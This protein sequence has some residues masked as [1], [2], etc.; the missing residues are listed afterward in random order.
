MVKELLE[1]RTK[2]NIQELLPQ[3]KNIE[4]GILDVIHRICVE[5][6]LKYSLAYGSLLG[7]VRHQG[8]IPWDDDIDIYMP[9]DDYK[10]FIEILSNN[11]VEGYVL[12]KLEKDNDYINN[13]AKLKKDNTTFLQP[14]EEEYKYHK[15]IFVDIFPCDLRADSSW[16]Q[17]M[18]KVDMMFKNLY[19]RQYVPQESNILVRLV[20]KLLLVIVPRRLHHKLSFGFEK[21]L[22]RKG[23]TG[24]GY[25][26]TS[27]VQTMSYILPQDIFEELELIPFEDRLYYATKKRKEVLT[28]VYGNYMELPPKV[29]RVWKHSPILIDFKHNYEDIESKLDNI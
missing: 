8:F 25:F 18:Q 5:N 13:F 2:L 22:I 7:A 29:E 16:N 12:L 4:M 10:Q 17:K 1:S 11:P 9:R 3:I 23:N 26:D 20:C 21:R 15:G 14:G 19:A 27:T 6:G 24:S 28:V